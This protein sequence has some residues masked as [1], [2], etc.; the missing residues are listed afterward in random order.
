MRPRDADTVAGFS[1]TAFESL[2][3]GVRY[4][5]ATLRIGPSEGAWAGVCGRGLLLTLI[6]VGGLRA[7]LVQESTTINGFPVRNVTPIVVV[8]VSIIS[9]AVVGGWRDLRQRVVCCSDGI[10]VRYGFFRSCRLDW[11]E[12]GAIETSSRLG[13]K[14][15]SIALRASLRPHYG[16][17]WP[18]ILT[19]DK[20]IVIDGLATMGVSE[21]WTTGPL[22]GAGQR[23]EIMSRYRAAVGVQGPEP[24]TTAHLPLSPWPPPWV[25]RISNVMFIIVLIAWS[26]I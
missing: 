8:G 22:S 6:G 16:H 24:V 21:Y 25:W 13:D 14:A 11:T 7:S 5:R 12:V 3:W 18:V 10:S 23:V 2:L 9:I 17:E 19:A 26:Q 1:L 15:I 20:A 4:D